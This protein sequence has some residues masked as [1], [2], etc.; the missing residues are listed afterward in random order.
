MKK[1]LLIILL[2]ALIGGGNYFYYQNYKNK[3]ISEGTPVGYIAPQKVKNFF[4]VTYPKAGAKLIAGEKVNITWDA[5]SF[6]LKLTYPVTLVNVDNKTTKLIEIGTAKYSFLNR[7]LPWAIPADVMPAKYKIVFG[8]TEGGESSVFEIVA[9]TK[10][11]VP[12]LTKSYS[13]IET[14][15]SKGQDAD[16]KLSIGMYVQ[17][18]GID[19]LAQGFTAVV[20]VRNVANG[21]V[22]AT[23]TVSGV[24]EPGLQTLKSGSKK[25]IEFTKFFG[26]TTFPIGTTNVKGFVQS[27]KYSTVPTD[28]ATTTTYTIS[29]DLEKFDTENQT[30]ITFGTSSAK[31]TFTRDLTLGSTGND[32]VQLKNFLAKKGYLVQMSETSTSTLF[33]YGMD[34]K[35]ALAKFQNA[36]GIS[37]ANGDFGVVT[38]AYINARLD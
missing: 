3:S 32:V 14:R 12:T 1:L 37:P 28:T 10:N 38:R 16:V 23:A 20:G 35:I 9:P 19:I 4:S 30:S 31:F 24:T 13:K 26:S 7:S 15:Q 5:L 17:P 34:L 2:I 29:N 22:I 36:N 8:G 11:Y 27:I 33:Y 25:Q 6:N 21:Q 18:G